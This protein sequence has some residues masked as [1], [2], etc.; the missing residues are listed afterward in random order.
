MF[1]GSALDLPLNMKILL[2]YPNFNKITNHE[3][4]GNCP[5]W[6][7]RA[8]LRTEFD[9]LVDFRNFFLRERCKAHPDL[10]KNSK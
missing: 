4:T 3:N 1:F 7:G 10:E 5:F 6:V 8:A 2:F 9:V